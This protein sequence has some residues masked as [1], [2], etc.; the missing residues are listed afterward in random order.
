VPETPA[1]RCC[2]E[3]TSTSKV[4]QAVIAGAIEDVNV[5]AVLVAIVA[6][7]H[8]AGAFVI[9]EGIESS[10]VLE[11]V[12]HADEFDVMRNLAI[13]GGQGFLLGRPS[14]EMPANDPAPRH[15]PDAAQ[16]L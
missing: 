9:A 1:S 7:A 12:R 10:K 13:E 8:R 2:G 6:Y 11:F 14:V 3:W 16:R 5:Q 4:D 15:H